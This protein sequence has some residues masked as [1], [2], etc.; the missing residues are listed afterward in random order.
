VI[1]AVPRFANLIIRGGSSGPVTRVPTCVPLAAK[2]PVGTPRVLPRRRIIRIG[3]A[4]APGIRRG[5]DV[6]THGDRVVVAGD[7]EVLKYPHATLIPNS[8]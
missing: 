2:M 5:I 1:L 8:Q 7:Y 3:D 4:R 6:L